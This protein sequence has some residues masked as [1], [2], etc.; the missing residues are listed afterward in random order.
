MPTAVSAPPRISLVI[1][2]YNRGDLVGATI[3]SALAQTLP[4]H[5]IIVVDDGSTDDTAAVLAGYGARIH[6][7]TLA[8][9]GVQRARNIGV[10]AAT[11]GYVALCD[12]DDL[13]APDFVAL[14]GA[15]LARHP[16]D[17][18]YCNFVTFDA[19][20]EDRD[21]FALAPAGFFDGAREQDGF[22]LDIP[23]L[24]ARIL[25]YQ[26]L[27]S[28]GV[29]L[30]RSFYQR[31]GGYDARFN[32]I[33]SEDLEF[34]M[35]A[36]AEGRVALCMRPLVRIRKHGGN[37]ST[38]SMRQ[39]GGTIQIIE[40]ALAQHPIAARYRER[41]LR[42]LD[43]RRVDVFDAAFARGQ[44]DLAR[45]MLEALGERPRDRR[46]RI[47]ALILGLPRLLRWPLWRLSQA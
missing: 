28:S 3:D 33:G 42:N 5:E 12:S 11:G 8:N 30:D 6:V 15:W 24:Y 38:D 37:D 13:L 46:F 1:P 19:R 34:T 35:R 22:L 14:T 9:G 26:L 17:A 7:I 25:D 10:E 18:V 36:V 21:K 20:G 29:V 45:R 16:C 4:F 31:L 43:L 27:F 44:F 41:I 23:D 32:R 40:F 2:A 39:V 47:K